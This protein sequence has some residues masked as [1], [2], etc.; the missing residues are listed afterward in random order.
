[1]CKP[2]P[3]E[4]WYAYLLRYVQ[5]QPRVVMAVIGW[6]A[7]VWIYLDF[8]EFLTQQGKILTKIELRIDHIERELEQQKN[9]PQFH[10]SDN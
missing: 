2:L 8:K 7:A 5:E 10:E 4:P 3:H 1:M 6:A 9:L